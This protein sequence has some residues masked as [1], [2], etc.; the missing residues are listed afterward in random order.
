MNILR[1]VILIA[2]ASLITACGGGGDDNGEENNNAKTGSFVD[3]PVEGLSYSTATQSGIT[4][5]AGEF[6][7]RDGEVVTFKIGNTVIGAAFGAEYITPLDVTNSFQPSDNAASNLARLLQT[8]DTDNNPENGITLPATVASLAE[9]LDINDTAEVETAISQTLIV[10]A[11]AESHLETSISALPPRVVEDVYQRVTIGSYNL[12][13]CPNVV[14]AE[15]TVSRD[16]SGNRVYD[17]RVEL[18]GGGQYLFTADDSTI[19]NPAVTD[20]PDH[21]YRINLDTFEGKIRIYT[22]TTPISECSEIRLTTDTSVNLPPLVRSGTYVT[23]IPGCTTA[24]STYNHTPSFWAYDKDGFIINDITVKFALDG[25]ELT[26]LVNQGDTTGCD[27]IADPM[28]WNPSS[29]GKGG[30]YCTASNSI[31]E[32]IP[33]I[34][35]FNWEAS[36]TDN[37]GLTTTITGS[38]SAPQES[39]G[40]VSGDIFVCSENYPSEACDILMSTAIPGSVTTN[41]PVGSCA[42]LVPAP[43]TIIDAAQIP[44][45]GAVNMI[46]NFDSFGS[47]EVSCLVTTDIP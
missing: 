26:T 47:S 19:Q 13:G 3:S 45:Q 41:H 14:D 44:P 4:N 46:I 12:S 25:G 9:N 2:I 28:S 37:E 38:S 1:I 7:Y 15:I 5:A 24:S 31:L 33:C 34:S 27:V 35:G 18:S 29:P 40:P 10:A 17:G 16:T 36:A 22:A 39:S 43:R 20:D 30:W 6:K 23:T 32:N 21:S 11:D 42:S 8:L